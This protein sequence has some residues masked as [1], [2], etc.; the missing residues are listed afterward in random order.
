[1]MG[2]LQLSVAK[3]CLNSLYSCNQ[4]YIGK[5]EGTDMSIAIALIGKDGIVLATDSRMTSETRNQ[6]GIHH[7]DCTKLWPVFDS[8]AVAAVGT[9]GGYESELVESFRTQIQDTLDYAQTV[10]GFTDYMREEWPQATRHLDAQTLSLYYYI[11]EFLFVGFQGDIPKI[12][13]IYWDGTQQIIAA[14]NVECGYYIAGTSY[15]AD[16]WLRNIGNYVS[17]MNIEELKR[18]VAM[19]IHESKYF[20]TVGGNIQ[21]ALVQKGIGVKMIPRDE[22]I[23]LEKDATR[24]LGRNTDSLIKKLIGN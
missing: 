5:R 9:I 23:Q 7:D 11:I 13:R 10:K 12:K 4:D 21:M 24:V 1:M 6:V 22:L 8:T 14:R 19:L 15:I 20:D 2:H 16:Y 17:A 3:E 18:F